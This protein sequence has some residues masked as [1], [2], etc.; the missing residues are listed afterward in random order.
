MSKTK[1]QTYMSALGPDVS[2][3]FSLDSFPRENYSAWINKKIKFSAHNERRL[4]NFSY[5][6]NDKQVQDDENFARIY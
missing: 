1:A 4:Q 6:C 2:S 5:L 3:N